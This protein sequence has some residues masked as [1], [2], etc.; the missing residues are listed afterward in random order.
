MNRSQSKIRHI[1][2][3][4][5]LLEQ[6]RILLKEDPTKHTPYGVLKAAKAG[7]IYGSNVLNSRANFVTWTNVLSSTT[8]LDSSWAVIL[9]CDNDSTIEITV[10]GN[11][12]TKMGEI[13][14]F[15]RAAT[16]APTTTSEDKGKYQVKTTGTY[17]DPNDTSVG[18]IFYN[19]LYYALQKLV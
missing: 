10:K 1:Q 6:R 17:S 5:V 19:M 18:N 3:T 8:G 4:N 7:E 16:N 13:E 15:F 9:R 11:D 2:K 14:K 12:K